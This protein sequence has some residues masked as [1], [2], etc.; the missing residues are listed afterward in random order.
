MNFNSTGKCNE[1][2]SRLLLFGFIDGKETSSDKL[3]EEIPNFI[4]SFK[5]TFYLT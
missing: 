5:P 3:L 1:I 2:L 4:L